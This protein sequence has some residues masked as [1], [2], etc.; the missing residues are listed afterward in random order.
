MLQNISLII[1]LLNIFLAITVIFLERRNATSTWA[2]LMILF[3]I[4]VLGFILYLVLGQRVRR[5]QLNKLLGDN[6]LIIEDTL[7]KQK[8]QVIERKLLSANSEHA[9]YQDMIY[10][11]LTTGYALYTNNNSVDIF[12]EGNQKFDSLIRDIEAAEHHIH[13]V[14]YIVRDDVLGRRLVKAL[15][16]KA[17]QGIE[18]RFLYDHIGSSQLPKRYFSELRAAGGWRLPF[19]LL[20]FLTLI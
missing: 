10:M 15:A 1:M 12:T 7:D 16:K 18:V 19:S 20:A 3:F 2:W 17:A 14:Y 8:Q 5:R 13:L 6:Q 4:P 9:M 11:N